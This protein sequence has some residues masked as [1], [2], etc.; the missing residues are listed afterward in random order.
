VTGGGPSPQNRLFIGGF[1][2]KIC[3]VSVGRRE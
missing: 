2:R 1:S 3:P